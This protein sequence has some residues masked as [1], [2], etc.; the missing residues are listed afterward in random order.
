MLYKSQAGSEANMKR[1]AGGRA[2]E[3]QISIWLPRTVTD[4]CEWL[5]VIRADS[6]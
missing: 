3:G 4:G 5:W 6:S 2:D 1:R